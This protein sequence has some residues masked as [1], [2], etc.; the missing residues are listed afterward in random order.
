VTV[1]EKS[2]ANRVYERYFH[3]G[4]RT[5][6]PVGHFHSFVKKY[7]ELKVA[8]RED[9]F[10][11]ATLRPYIDYA[12]SY[13]NADGRI[14]NAKPLYYGV[15]KLYLFYK[16]AYIYNMYGDFGP[17][18]DNAAKTGSLK[19]LIKDPVE[20]PGADTEQIIE[21]TGVG[22]VTNNISVRQPDISF[23]NNLTR[24]STCVQVVPINPIGINTAVDPGPLKPQKLYSAIFLARYDGSDQ[25]VHRFVFQTSRYAGFEEQINSF[26]LHD[27]NGVFLRDAVYDISKAFSAAQLTKA[28]QQLTGALPDTDPLL[29]AYQ[30]A[31]DL[32]MTGI[33]EMPA[34]PPAVTTEVNVVR[35]ASDNAI[36][37]LL[38][39][40]PEPLND[41]KIPAMVLA[42]SIALSV[43]GGPATDHKAIF[44]KDIANVFISN[45]AL[46]LAAGPV[47]MNFKYYQFNGA[48]Y[49][50]LKSVTASLTI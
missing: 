3:C 48:D 24:G 9:E 47:A 42:G 38:V 43:N 16:F 34:L 8:D 18:N 41:P 49:Q 11:L 46:S 31:Y 39:R 30:D 17:Y 5:K 4:F 19:V 26:K 22:F 6:G 7:Q 2:S 14:T 40:S 13:P 29:N 37:G 21:Q 12:K 27:D 50:E 1:P 44:S 15:P 32:L 25:E 28:A 10:Q 35:N 20:P 45:A 36:L 33:L 23:F